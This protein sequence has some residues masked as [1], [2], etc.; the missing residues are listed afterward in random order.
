MTEKEVEQKFKVG[1]REL[2][3]K[4]KKATTAPVAA[5]SNDS[6]NVMEVPDIVL[7]LKVAGKI[8]NFLAG[9]CI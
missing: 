8:K 1:F 4:L 7:R 6:S 9:L 2:F 5:L 3:P